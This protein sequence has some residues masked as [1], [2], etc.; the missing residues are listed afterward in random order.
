MTYYTQ[1]FEGHKYLCIL[2]VRCREK[3]FAVPV[4]TLL[5]IPIVCPKCG[6]YK[7]KGEV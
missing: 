2:C 7:V 3:W 4:S 5:P 6:E 1:I